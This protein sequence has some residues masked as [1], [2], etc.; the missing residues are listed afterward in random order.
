[1][2]VMH[3]RLAEPVGQ[4]EEEGT[5]A[6]DLDH[7]TGTDAVVGPHAGRAARQDRQKTWL[8]GQSETGCAVCGGV[9][10]QPGEERQNGSEGGKRRSIARQYVLC[11]T[12]PKAS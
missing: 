12:R 1:M 4:Q 7:G 8:R 5:T 10:T 3:D 6:L 11:G 2:K 9:R